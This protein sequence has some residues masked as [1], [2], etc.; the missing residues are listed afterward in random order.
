[1]KNKFIKINDY[2]IIYCESR[3][4]EVFEVFIDED[5]FEKLKNS[6]YSI[7]AHWHRDSKGY[8]ATIT[9]YVNHNVKQ[10]YKSKVLHQMILPCPKGKMIDHINN[11]RLDNRKI[12]LRIV[13]KSNN[14]RNRKSKNSNNTSGYRNVTWMGNHWRVQLQVNGKNK[15][16]TEKFEDVHEA[17]AFAEKMRN[18]HYGKFSGKN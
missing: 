12:N 3:K 8:Y 10:K 16:F 7:Y 6:K 14:L 9:E 4:K 1:M 15:L 11:N 13:N 5:V 18:K 2:Y 17:G